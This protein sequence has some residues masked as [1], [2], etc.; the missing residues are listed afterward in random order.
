MKRKS[1]ISKGTIAQIVLIL[2]VLYFIHKIFLIFF[3]NLFYSVSPPLEGLTPHQ[4]QNLLS[5]Y[6]VSYTVV[7]NVNSSYP[8]GTIA[9][10]DPDP[11]TLVKQGRII[12]VFISG[13]QSIQSIPNIVGEN[14][15]VAQQTLNSGGYTVSI[16]YFDS[17]TIANNQVIAMDPPSGSVSS[18]S[19]VVTLLVSSGS[20]TQTVTVPNLIG[21][22]ITDA[23]SAIT[24]A[25]LLVGT[26]STTDGNGAVSNSV[27][28]SSPSANASVSAGTSINLTIAQ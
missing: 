22:D 25:N 13:N 14:Y 9:A 1:K 2:A 5:K 24:S 27:V 28:S 12:Q 20:T 3:F 17:P 19:N 21:M 7:G 8:D 26:T 6:H 4:A 11:F 18:M 16:I 15:Q 10:Q 23:K